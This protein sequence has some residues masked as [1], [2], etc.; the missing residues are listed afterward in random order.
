MGIRVKFIIFLLAFGFVVLGT[1]V[2]STQFVLQKTI[3]HY[4]DQRDQQRLERL[5]NNVEVYLQNQPL[6]DSHDISLTAWQRLT[7]YSHRMDFQQMPEVVPRMMERIGKNRRSSLPADEF[8][9]RVTLMT[10]SSD[11]LYGQKLTEASVSLPIVK[12]GRIFAQIGYHPLSKITEQTDIEF[13]NSQFKMFT[14]GAVL[15]TLLALLLLWPLGN[16]FLKPVRQLNRAM[17]R[18]AAGKLDERLDV[19]RKDEIGALQRDFNHLAA[20]LEAAQTSRN[21]WIADI[22]HELRTPLTVI[23]GSIEAMYDGI[24]PLNN[25]SLQLVQKEVAVLQRL[26]EDLYQLSLSDVGALQYSMQRVDLA[27]ITL[28]CLEALQ[29][30]ALQKGLTIDSDIQ[31]EAW[32]YGDANRLMQLVSNLLSNSLNYTD[33]IASDGQAGKVKISL[34]EHDGSYQLRIMDSSPGVSADELTRLTDRFYRT[35]PS[36]NRRTGG[37]GLGLAMVSQIAKAHDAEL[38][39]H[40]SG[41]GGLEVVLEFAKELTE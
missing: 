3:L 6:D 23:N 19:K 32:I 15:I 25:D 20:T 37:A 18:L 13:A 26:I 22:S 30:K 29:N 33:A 17:H 40:H 4:V 21:Q 35:D 1:L 8:E 14:G 39:L 10:P 5:K 2:W 28:Q 38:R 27:E 16:H 24:R 31:P 36:R 11:V 7:F 41:L 12:N 34:S 9:S